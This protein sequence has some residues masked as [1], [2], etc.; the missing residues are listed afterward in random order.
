MQ[1]GSEK[2][3]VPADWRLTHL[4]KRK[5]L[6]S[7]SRLRLGM[8]QKKWDQY[9]PL[10][11]YRRNH[12][13]CSCFLFGHGLTDLFVF[14]ICSI[15]SSNLICPV[16]QTPQTNQSVLEIFPSH[17]VTGSRVNNSHMANLKGLRYAVAFLRSALYPTFRA[18]SGRVG[19]E[20]RWTAGLERIDLRKHGEIV[21]GQLEF[22]NILILHL[23]ILFVGNN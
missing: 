3:Q 10:F 4:K 14:L 16:P 8:Q 18:L 2:S 21:H 11:E 7:T 5:T 19:R 23:K 13:S 15:T 9:L 20:H 17:Q 6:K 22:S 12:W 1:L